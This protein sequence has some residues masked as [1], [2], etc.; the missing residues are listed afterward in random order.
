MTKLIIQIPCYNEAQTLPAT[1]RALPRKLA[2]IDQIEY[3]VIDDGSRDGTTEVA[4]SLGI[5]HIVR[6][7]HNKGLAMGFMAGLEACIRQGADIIVNTDADNQYQADDIP[8]LIEPLLAGRA[9]IAVGD[10][11]VGTLQQFSRVKRKLQQLGSWVIKLASGVHTPDATSGFR[12]LTRDAALRTLVLH[13]YSYTLETLISAGARRA[14][15]EFVP[16]RVNPQTRPSRLMKSTAQ[17]VRISSGTIVRTYAMYRPLVVFSIVGAVLIGLGSIPGLRFLYFYFSGN[18]LGHIQSLILAAI[19]IIVG[20]QVLLIGLVA[21]L[22][23]FNRKILEEVLYR[24]RR[25]DM[26]GGTTEPGGADDDGREQRTGAAAEVREAL[27]R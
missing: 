17:Y 10:R 25:V 26:T 14:A 13:G 27:S 16:I 23:S 22:I 4:R 19:L 18:P 1:V 12:A 11:G 15:V 24:M 3:L 9:E 5:H 6:F 20:F 8:R 2:G 7:S 21:D